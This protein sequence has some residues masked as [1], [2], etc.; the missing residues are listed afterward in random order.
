MG[1]RASFNKFYNQHMA[2]SVCCLYKEAKTS[3]EIFTFID[4]FKSIFGG[5]LWE[6]YGHFIGIF[7]GIF[8]ANIYTLNTNGKCGKT[9]VKIM[10]FGSN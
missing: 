4:I 10:G 8:A 3:A 5:I 9:H 1:D 7:K 6:F 2:R